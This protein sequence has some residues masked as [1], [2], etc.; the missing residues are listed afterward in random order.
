MS[1]VELKTNSKL[2]LF[3]EERLRV[4]SYVYLS[5]SMSELN[6]SPFHKN[7]SKNIYF[8]Y[9]PAGNAI[10]ILQQVSISKM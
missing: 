1:K 3:N 4:K 8:L 6:V 7:G 2:N 10:N 5:I 9:Y